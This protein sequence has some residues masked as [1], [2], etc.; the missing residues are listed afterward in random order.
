MAME[1]RLE[2]ESELGMA[3]QLDPD[4]Q[5]RMKIQQGVQPQQLRLSCRQQYY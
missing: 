3:K 5:T 1:W 4:M 2:V